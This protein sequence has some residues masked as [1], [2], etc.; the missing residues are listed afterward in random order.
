MSS[1]APDRKVPDDFPEELRF[2][3]REILRNWPGSVEDDDARGWALKVRRYMCIIEV[4]TEKKKKKDPRGTKGF[5]LTPLSLS[6]FE[7]E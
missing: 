1:F 3:T 2:L 7:V 6:R 4:K 5:F